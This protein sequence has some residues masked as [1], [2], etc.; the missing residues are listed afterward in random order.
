MRESCDR[1]GALL[2]FDETAICLGRTGRMFACEHFGVVPD[3]LTL[4]KGLGG[5]VMPFAAV[6]A[7]SHLDTV[8]E[9]SLGHYTHEKN[10]V[11]CAAGLAA[12]RVIE[13]ENLAARAG[14]MGAY[15]VDRLRSLMERHP[16]IGD[17]RG[18]GLFLGL[19]LV[20]DR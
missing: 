1:H 10:P 5:G 15:A 2:V 6:I 14:E 3:I 17:V 4:G 20:L 9:K 18:V 16:R 11:A 12:I 7:G 19:E 8:P 13:R